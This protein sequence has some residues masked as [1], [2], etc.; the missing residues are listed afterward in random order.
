LECQV[1]EVDAWVVSSKPMAKK[2]AY[3]QIGDPACRHVA[4]DIETTG[5]YPQ[6]GARVIEIGAAAIEGE[7]GIRNW[8]R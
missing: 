5:L 1:V 6:R 3:Q 8:G 7:S 2:S 4:V